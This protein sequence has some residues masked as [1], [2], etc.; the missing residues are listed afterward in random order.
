MPYNHLT[1][2]DQDRDI[3]RIEEH[4]NK[5]EF[6]INERFKLIS[7]RISNLEKTH[8]ITSENFLGVNGK[9]NKN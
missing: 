4:L 7:Q 9:C 8:K 6:N 3:I 5:I 2:Q 1:D